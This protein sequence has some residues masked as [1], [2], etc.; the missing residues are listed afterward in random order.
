MMYVKS[1]TKIPFR[2][3]LHVKTNMVAMAIFFS[4]WLKLVKGKSETT[5]SNDLLVRTNNVQLVAKDIRQIC[6][7]FYWRADCIFTIKSYMAN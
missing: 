5:K 4:D 2:F 7:P 1:S 6:L 3:D